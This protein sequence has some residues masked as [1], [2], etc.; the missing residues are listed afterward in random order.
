MNHPTLP[1]KVAQTRVRLLDLVDSLPEGGA[2]P[3]ERELA[4]RWGI[5]RMT[6]R[7]A[8]DELVQDGLVVR[9]HGKGTFTLRPKVLRRLAMTSF[10]ED[11]I[12]RG[13]RPASR[14]LEFRRHRAGHTLSRR[15]RMPIG[16]P[17]IAYTRL[18]LA[19]DVP[20][21]LERSSIPAALVPG[22]RPADLDGSWYE[23][24]TN[25][26]GIDMVSATF[27]VEPVLA[28]PRTAERLETRTGQP[29]LQLQVSSFDGHGHVVEAGTTIYRGDRYTLTA[30]LRPTRG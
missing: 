20:M 24:L 16:D 2:L 8:V 28:D 4:Q 3:P 26:Y 21:A 5:A 10:T 23:L 22:L 14:T 1:V 11:M 27:T 7:R 30:E 25:R 12:R 9:R 17:V 15:L 18:R 29:C 6:L 19:D 13:M